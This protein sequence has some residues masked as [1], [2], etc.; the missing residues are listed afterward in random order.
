[1]AVWLRRSFGLCEDVCASI[2]SFLKE[3]VTNWTLWEAMNACASGDREAMARV[4]LL[5]T[6]RAPGECFVRFVDRTFLGKSAAAGAKYVQQCAR[7]CR[8]L[9]MHHPHWIYPKHALSSDAYPCKAT[10]FH[11]LLCGALVGRRV[12][13]PWGRFCGRL[14]PRR[15]LGS[16]QQRACADIILRLSSEGLVGGAGFFP[17]KSVLKAVMDDDYPEDYAHLLAHSV[18]P[19]LPLQEEVLVALFPKFERHCWSANGYSTC[20]DILVHAMF[21]VMESP[22]ALAAIVR[23]MDGHY[24]PI[25]SSIAVCNPKGCVAEPRVRAYLLSTHHFLFD[26]IRQR[27]TKTVQLLLRYAPKQVAALRDDRNRTALD[28]ACS[29]RGLTQKLIQLLLHSGLFPDP[30]GTVRR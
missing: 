19:S 26:M 7:C 5:G 30:A 2:D 27:K 28:A 11:M 12:D 6:E 4:L 15:S 16:E 18:V 25:T 17:M 22:A 8:L 13:D 10:M 21:A 23:A 14:G 24:V 29:C 1:M 20:H 9:L 3:S